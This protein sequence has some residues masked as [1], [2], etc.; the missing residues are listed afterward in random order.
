LS[1]DLDLAASQLERV[2]AFLDSQGRKYLDLG[3]CAVGVGL[4]M[5][6]GEPDIC[7]LSVMV[8]MESTLLITSGVLK[9]VNR[10]RLAVLDAC[11][12]QTRGNPTFPVYLH[13]AEVSWDI[14]CQMQYPIDFLLSLPDFFLDCI[15]SVA[16]APKTFGPA[17]NEKGISGELWPWNEEGA[18][19]LLLRSM[20]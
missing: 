16:M 17:F 14:L 9:D 8:E 7:V 13:D 12:S 1:D 20:F 11:N 5:C 18:P 15:R 10:D 19:A 3:E 2:K 6:F 4:G